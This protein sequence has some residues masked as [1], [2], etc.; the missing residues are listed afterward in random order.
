M[1]KIHEEV[2][3]G[4]QDWMALRCGVLTASDMHK[5]VTETTL[6]AANN[7]KSRAH[8]YEILSQ[9]ITK[10][11]EPTYENMNMLRGYE[12]EIESRRLYSENYA[13]VTEVG[14]ITNDKWGFTLGYSPDGLVGDDGL[15][16][17]K[18][19]AQKYQI[20]TILNGTVPPE[21]VMQLQTGLLVSEREW[22]DFIS[23]CGG[24]P[25]YTLRVYPDAKIQEAI[26]EAARVFY[27]KIDEMILQ[28]S[29]KLSTE[30]LRLIATE[31][32]DY[33]TGGMHV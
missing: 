3:Q 25:M 20:Q 17:C 14:F 15:I 19:R 16:E 22:I 13:P 21:Y 4:S 30:H 6:K 5:I 10:H 33:S 18:S 29:E 32:Q 26:I 27:D 1:I 28:F 23:Y 8:V 31:R 2:V 7:D 24:L 11:V 12:D 9:K